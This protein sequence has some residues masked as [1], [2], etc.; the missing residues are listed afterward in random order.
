MVLGGTPLRLRSVSWESQLTAAVS[1]NKL[2]S[3]G[4]VRDEPILAGYRASQRYDEGKPLAAFYSV[5]VSYNADG[6]PVR[7]GSGRLVLGDTAYVGPSIPTRELGFTNT[8]TLLRD[9]TL[10]SFL[11][12]KGGHY[13]FNMT[14]QTA[15]TDNLSREQVLR[16]NAADSLRAEI[17]RSGATAPFMSP[18]DFLKL[19]E[20]SLTYSVPAHLT[21]RFGTNRMSVALAG[22]NLWMWT[23]YDGPD[24]EVNIEGD[25]TFTRSDYMSVPATRQWVATVNLTF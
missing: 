1:H 17:L 4:G 25:A 14:Q 2:V 7:D 8:F 9:F 23:R 18:A 16:T 3:W 5:D 22:R 13:Q 15:N 19:R 21:Q 20:L 24:P 12:Y 10:F 6:T 11:D